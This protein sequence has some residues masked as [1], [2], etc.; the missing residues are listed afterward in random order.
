MLAALVAAAGCN[1]TSPAD[2]AGSRGALTAPPD[3]RST[4]ESGVAALDAE[5][6]GVTDPETR[7]RLRD[8]RM[9]ALAAAVVDI[10]PGDEPPRDEISELR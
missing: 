4:I 6:A 3:V 2:I 5:L 10:A 1:D 9:H 8:A 7:C